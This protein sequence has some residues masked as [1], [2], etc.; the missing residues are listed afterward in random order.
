MN[1]PTQSKKSVLTRLPIRYLKELRAFLKENTPGNGDR[2][3]GLGRA[4]LAAGLE[5]LDL[6]RIHEQTMVKLATSFD[7]PSAFNDLIAR[8]GFFFNQALIPLQA[9]QRATLETNRLLLQ[10]NE[11][12]R[13]GL[14][15]WQSARLA[16][17][18]G[19]AF[20]YIAAFVAPMIAF[21]RYLARQ[22]KPFAATMCE[23][24][25]DRACIRTTN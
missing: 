15:F 13:V 19:L 23:L 3:Q 18:G 14:R 9:A 20:L 8:A 22:P 24:A 17:L 11:T 21:R 7:F 1:E 2:A 12:W 10:K 5:P 4:A 6:A 16:V 25:T